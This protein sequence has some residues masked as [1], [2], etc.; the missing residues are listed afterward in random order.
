MVAID[1]GNVAGV[2]MLRPGA[3]GKTLF[4]RFDG[5]DFRAGE[6]SAG[7][8]RLEIPSTSNAAAYVLAY[9][10][11]GFM[12]NG[13]P[14]D[15]STAYAIEVWDS[16]G[17]RIVVDG[18]SV[19]FP[20]LRGA[21]E[22][23]NLSALFSGHALEILGAKDFSDTLAGGSLADEIC[24]YGG[25][26]VLL[27]NAGNDTLNGMGGRDTMTGGIGNDDYYV[28]HDDDVIKE[29]SGGGIDLAIV[30]IDY[31]LPQ[32]VDDLGLLLTAGAIDGTGNSLANFMAGNGSV[33][34]LEGLGGDDT[35]FGSGGDDVLNGGADDDSL[36]GGNGTDLLRIFGNVDFRTIGN[37]RVVNIERLDLREGE[38][39]LT[40]TQSDVL[41]M[42]PTDDIRVF[43]DGLDTVNIAGAQ[44]A[45][46]PVADGFTRY[47][48]GAATLY[49]DSDIQVI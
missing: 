45:G 27:G 14:S 42:S 46:V 41:A 12:P 22:D 21:L 31:T 38:H 39:R 2:N 47:R 8:G 35:L 28:N 29:V 37:G 16:R 36:V 49:I 23:K 5:F 40:L 4:S 32:F 20:T 1:F 13:T 9:G 24:G 43:G 33:N 34:T 26:D 48:I 18:F 30:S 15:N 17:Y 11:W 25:N 3:L 19:F 6:Y 44:S 7:I 10:T